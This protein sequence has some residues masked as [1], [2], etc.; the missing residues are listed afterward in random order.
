MATATITTTVRDYWDD[1]KRV[2]ILATMDFDTGDYAAGGIAPTLTGLFPGQ[3][4]TPEVISLNG[5]AGYVYEWDRANSKVIVRNPAAH[6]HTITITGG[7]AGTQAIGIATD[8]N[9]AAL[10]KTTATDRTGITGIQ[11]N[12][13]APLAEVSVAQ[14]PSAVSSDVIDVYL[15]CKKFV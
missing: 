1:G 8:A 5:K 14:L 4:S 3:R 13:V 15:V 10:S 2:H 11:N 6:T 7:A 12:T 9:A